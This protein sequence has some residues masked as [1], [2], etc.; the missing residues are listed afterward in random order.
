[1][2]LGDLLIDDGADTDPTDV[3]V[4]SGPRAVTR[5]ELIAATE[6]VSATLGS[7]GL[8]PGTP[9]AVML[10]GPEA[11]A[12][13]FGVW[14]A[15][16]VH[17]PLNP[18][19]TDAEV[20]RVLT[21]VPV[22]V[23]VTAPDTA[24]RVPAGMAHMVVDER[25]ARLDGDARATTPTPLDADAALVQLTSGTTGPPKP[26]VLHHG[27]IL[28]LMDRVLD[29]LGAKRSDRERAP[30]PNLVPLSLSLWAGIYNVCFAFRV[31][32]P[33]VLLERFEPR[34]FAALVTRHQIRSV[35][36]PPAAMAMLADDADLESLEPLR[37]VRSIT[38]PLSPFQARRFHARFGV[39]VLNSYG[40]TELGG[41]VIGWS[42]GDLPAFGV[43]KLGAVGRPHAGVEVRVVEGELQVRTGRTVG[44]DATS[45]SGDDRL[46]ADGWFRTGDLAQIDDDGFVWI[47]GRV[48]EMINRGG[49]KVYPGEVEE[50]LRA[51][52]GVVDAAVVGAPDERLG[53]VPVAFVVGPVDERLEARCR[54]ELAPY[55]VPAR[56]VAVD[57]LP[58]TEVGKV[59]PRALLALLAP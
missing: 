21:R 34:E 27:T 31:G 58:R 49:L 56:F 55:K 33:V 23:V 43:T 41:E 37:L 53:E 51:V 26:V 4:H 45:T 20:A 52:P 47:E 15:G 36:L 7:L 19:L 13:L 5:R 12:A 17:V 42:A 3:V 59:I 30:M 29:T 57:Q 28:A 10:T 14:R 32:A 11:I 40:Q 9:V 39:D 25:S 24:S 48:S 46:G 35:V 18:R 38:A 1:V 16:L 54:A 8:P 44:T 22:A 2:T 6:R 50:V